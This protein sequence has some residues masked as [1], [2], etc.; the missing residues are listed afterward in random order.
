MDEIQLR[1]ILSQ[2]IKRFRQRKGWSQAKLAE[3]MEI[4][5]NYL[6][7]IETK[8]GW[9]SP[10]SLVKMANALEVDVFELFKKEISVPEDTSIIV[11][12]C[13]NDLS[14]SLKVS[15]EKSLANSIQKIQKSLQ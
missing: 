7:D 5:T 13:L 4:S 2:N 10:F 15:F 3:K 1:N 11:N 6:S 12:R 8:R 14:I 9:V